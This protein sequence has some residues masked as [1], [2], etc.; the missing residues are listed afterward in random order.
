MCAENKEVLSAQLFPR[1]LV[2]VAAEEDEFVLFVSVLPSINLI[3]VTIYHSRTTYS[4]K[5][6]SRISLPLHFSST[7]PQSSSTT[8]KNY[9][10]IFIDSSFM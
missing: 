7:P 6:P 1:S 8:V 5:F 9:T 10:E 2:A 3:P 4:N